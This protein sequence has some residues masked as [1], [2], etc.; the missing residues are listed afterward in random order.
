[1]TPTLLDDILDT[2][3]SNSFE[4]RIDYLR[5]KNYEYDIHETAVN[6]TIENITTGTNSLVV[7]GEPQSGKTEY[8]IA[9]VCKLLDIEKKTIIILTNDN[10]ELEHQ[11]YQRFKKTVQ[12]NTSVTK[13]LQFKDLRDEDKRSDIKR[14]IFCRKN[15][16]NLQSLIED[17]RFLSNIVIIDDEADFASP[18]G[19]INKEDPSKINSLIRDLGNFHDGGIYIGVT[20]TPGRLDLN[21]TFMNDSNKWIFLRSH[22]NYKGRSFFFPT[23][24]KEG[25]KS[26]YIL[27]TLPNAGDD[28]K[29]L[30]ESF[31][32]FLTRSTILNLSKGEQKNYSMLIHTAGRIADHEDDQKQVQKYL[33]HLK[34]A[35]QYKEKANEYCIY[36]QSI[37]DELIRDHDHNFESKHVLK[38]IMD[39]INNSEIYIINHKKDRTNTD[40]VCNPQERFTIGIGGN[41][42]SRG[43]TFDGLLTFFFSRSVKGKFQQNTY[44]QRARMFG[45]RPY[46]KYF[47][48]CIPSD[49][50][51]SWYDCFDH[52]EMSL[53]S[54]KAGD[55]VHIYSN[56]T[57][58]ADS[59]SID[60]QH[61]QYFKGEHAVG[62]VFKMPKNIENLFTNIKVSNAPIDF[63]ESLIEN[64]T[65]PIES[66]NKSFLSII[67]ERFPEGQNN[68]KI[69]MSGNEFICPSNYNDYD[70]ITI[71]R[72]RGG[73][74][75]ATIQNR[76]EYKNKTIILPVKSLNGEMRFYFKSNDG[77]KG[78][79]RVTN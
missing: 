41:I 71:S 19:R 69:V 66:F 43:L 64:N 29:H 6:D 78:L 13:Y 68:I 23:S 22:K 14:I 76:D 10:T 37:A 39:N 52:H 33:S 5:E 28:P 7:Y 30:R 3:P 73:L 11:N 38:S 16:N 18:D 79:Q 53:A 55:Y 51:Q 60:K 77:Y 12:I 56:Q 21:G 17:S 49:L 72:K 54:A 59:S 65:L 4:A 24:D 50:Y 74:I 45:N 47:E 63:I 8:M 70:P 57:S 2:S 32:R 44:I 46:A 27:T 1:M 42:V 34:D 40:A 31:L 75:A 61:I 15:T 67:R 20:A 62:P 26:N 48:L 25:K 35:R 58:A 9:L 36:M